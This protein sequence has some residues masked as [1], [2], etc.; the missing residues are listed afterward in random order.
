MIAS[1]FRAVGWV[2]GVAAAALSCY[3][4]SLQ[5][6]SERA[7]LMSME[8][9]TLGARQDI[10]QLRTELDTRSRLVQLERW[11]ADVLGLQAPQV[12]QYAQGEM[13]LAAYVAPKAAPHVIQASL[14]ARPAAPV[15]T[16][17]ALR[18][19]TA[20][21]PAPAPHVTPLPAQR[22]APHVVLASASMPSRGLAELQ[23]MI[24]RATYSPASPA[25]LADLEPLVQ[26]AALV[27]R[28]APPGSGV[29]KLA[30]QTGPLLGDDLMGDIGRRAAL[31]AKPKGR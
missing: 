15:V 28:A 30:G 4:V 6:A 25:R 5:V 9:K 14:Q 18:P 19:E 3:L 10:R 24:R 17:A 13:Q 12:S 16:P 23:P 27:A 11:N 29:A 8:R 1:R 21:A 26:K 31:E 7:Q 20:P 22:V 2:A